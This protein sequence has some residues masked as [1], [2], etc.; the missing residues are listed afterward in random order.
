[1][2][3]TFKYI[4]IFL[5]LCAR[6]TGQ[7]EQ[8]LRD[9]TIIDSVL[10]KTLEEKS[11]E[12]AFQDTARYEA[13]EKFSK[14]SKL[15]RT[16]HR[17]FFRPIIKETAPKAGFEPRTKNPH[18]RAQGKII[19]KIVITTL[20]PFGY[21][22]SDTSVHPE[23]FPLKT[24]NSLHIKTK[25]T[26][27]RNLLLFREGQ[28]YDSLLIKESS[29]LIR[30]QKYVRDMIQTSIPV[31]RDSIDVYIRISDVWSI[32]PSYLGTS[33]HLGLGIRDLNFAGLG[34]SLDLRTTWDRPGNEN[35]THISY[36][37][38][39]IRNSYISLNAQYLFSLNSRLPDVMDYERYFYSPVSYN[40]EYIFSA[41]KN[42]TR[43]I[44]MIRPFYS[45][46]AKWAGGIFLG[47]IMT[48][49]SYMNLDSL[50]YLSSLTNIQDIWA[51]R[52]WQLFKK[53]SPGESITSLVLS[54]RLVRTRSPGRPQ[55]AID[56]N[57][58][59]KHKYFFGNI[60]ISSRKYLLDKYIFNYGKIE[61]V[62]V[63]RIFG[64]TIGMDAQQK[65]RIYLGFNA[66]W[67]AYHSFG[68]LSTQLSY[69]TFKGQDGFEQGTLTGRIDYYTRLLTMG[70]WKL[71]QFIRPS[72]AFGINTVPTD[73]Q[74]L[75]VSIKGFESFESTAINIRTLSLQTQ[76]YAPWDLAGFRFGPYVF[77]HLGLIG[78]ESPGGERNHRFY[79][80][81][82]LGMLIKNDYLMF[83][84]F[85]ISLSFYPFLPERGNNI[86][87][88]NAYKTS[89]YGFR[90]FEVSKPGI[91][92]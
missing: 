21:N 50:R 33:S 25:E 74:P 19:R 11:T 60:S 31:T 81:I 84:T 54:A 24:G 48:T 10:Y 37:M 15:T 76:S 58:F 78:N 17:I 1:M 3:M 51:G 6:L 67:G 38:P 73:N 41:N 83:S 23:I 16:L 36:L 92:E 4:L 70:N 45:P 65:N 72:F 77:T 88:T 91:V 8:P 7:Q 35:I 44:E 30:S 75:R 18:L 90:N 39:N 55:E 71:R 86:F 59:N 5:C 43:S 49:Q 53:E 66:G 52:S 46:T 80:L 26:V 40:P 14:K 28:K 9:S 2:R 85:Q 63:G 47:R 69:G 22:L 62:P 27:I 57:V 89:D 29:R 79:S 56:A 12:K 87:R 20:D 64:V 13:L 61:D 68:Y 34:N 42:I 82:G 32:V